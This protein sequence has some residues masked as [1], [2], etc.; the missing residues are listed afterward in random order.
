[1]THFDEEETEAFMKIYF[2]LRKSYKTNRDLGCSTTNAKEDAFNR[3]NEYD[4]NF[5]WEQLKSRGMT[6]YDC[7]SPN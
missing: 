1:M 6:L 4:T 3:I 7:L 5:F 2:A